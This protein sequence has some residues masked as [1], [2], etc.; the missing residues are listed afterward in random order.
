MTAES[1]SGMFSLSQTHRLY[2]FPGV[3]F[4]HFVNGITQRYGS[5]NI[6]TATPSIGCSAGVNATTRVCL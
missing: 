4:I 1:S 3:I 6:L 2:N 5:I